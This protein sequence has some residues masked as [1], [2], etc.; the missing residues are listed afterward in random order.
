M[1]NSLPY[2]IAFLLASVCIGIFGCTVQSTDTSTSSEVATS[3]PT[4]PVKPITN[5]TSSPNGSDIDS[6]TCLTS[7]LRFNFRQELGINNIAYLK[8]E[9][10]D[11]LT[12]QG[13]TQRPEPN[14]TPITPE[15]TPDVRPEPNTSSRI[16]FV[17]G[18]L[19]IL[20]EK[21]SSLLLDVSS[22]LGNPCGEECPLEVISQSP[23]NEW[24]LIQVSDWLRNKNGVWLVSK[25][26]MVRLVPF[27]SDPWWRW[28]N[29]N[30]L[31]WFTSNN[32]NDLG[33]I[34]LLVHL[35]KPVT[36]DI[37]EN[38]GLLDTFFYFP[39]FS[40]LNKNVQSVQSFEQGA[41]RT[42]ELFTIDISTS[43][44]QASESRLVPG[45]VSVDWNDTTQS[46]LVQVVTGNGVEI[47]DI[48]GD[49]LITIPLDTLKTAIPSLAEGRVELTGISNPGNYGLSSSGSRLVVVRNNEE[50]WLFDCE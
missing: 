12:F 48:T 15:P 3:V 30:S 14:V 16:L 23:N 11:L 49:V 18:Q 36:I 38:G 7:P 17:S 6:K 28:S 8:F 20:D 46:F 2:T 43:L 24:Q 41:N 21:F 44:T 35:N 33:G 29:D 40:P 13:W 4:Q 26:E 22:P 27:V 10:E 19:S 25:E 31:L 42:E 34:T 32:P 45:I 39:A 1:R 9:N 37:A 50:F 47:Q 5:A